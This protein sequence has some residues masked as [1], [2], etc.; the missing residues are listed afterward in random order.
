VFGLAAFVDIDFVESLGMMKK[1]DDQYSPDEA[2]ERM[3]AALL[4][5]RV[6]GHVPMKPKKAV[7]KAKPKKRGLPKKA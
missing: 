6:V 5:A 7:K 4:G 2:K 1:P 3:R